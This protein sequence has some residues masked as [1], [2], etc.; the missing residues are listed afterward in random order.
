MPTTE[1][2]DGPPRDDP[3]S[4]RS[5]DAV[6]AAARRLLAEE[7]PAAVTHQRV[8]AESGV[9]RATVYRHWPSP[10]ALLRD[11]LAAAQMPFFLDGSR[12][13]GEAAR[14][15]A[16]SPWLQG[17][18]RL[19]ADQLADPAF[20]RFTASLVLEAQRDP[21]TRAHRDEL[22][23]ALD[24]RLAAVLRGTPSSPGDDDAEDVAAD[25]GAA[26]LAARL[27][28]PLVYRTL[29]QGRPVT[30]AFLERTI[31]AVLGR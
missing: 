7:G 15:D 4:A 8:A 12:D 22:V 21:A 6:L 29:L 17:Q 1:P 11:V 13:G 16:P 27:I 5:R 19:M 31:A 3:R 20:A 24:G 14:L 2:A 10:E 25:E 26:D 30:D 28:G 18:L 9:G 23:G